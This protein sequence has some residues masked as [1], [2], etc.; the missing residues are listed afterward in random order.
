MLGRRPCP[1]LLAT[2]ELGGV[3][4]ASVGRTTPVEER[5]RLVGGLGAG[6]VRAGRSLGDVGEGGR[7][8]AGS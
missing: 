1:L 3:G 2:G 5:Q 6:A 4:V 7:R 8:S